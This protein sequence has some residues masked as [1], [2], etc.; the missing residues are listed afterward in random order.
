MNSLG[1]VFQGIDKLKEGAAE[2]ATRQQ[3]AIK[4]SNDLSETSEAL[5]QTATQTLLK[6]SRDTGQ[7]PKVAVP[8]KVFRRGKQKVEI[9]EDSEDNDGDVRAGGERHG[10]G[11]GRA[12]GFGRGIRNGWPR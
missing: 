10:V 9:M 11:D 8:K 12:V 3:K 2:L 7:P 6:W 4:R 1:E 5:K